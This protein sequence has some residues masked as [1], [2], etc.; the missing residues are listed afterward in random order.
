MDREEARKNCLAA[1]MRLF[2][3]ESPEDSAAILENAR[4]IWSTTVVSV[5]FGY[6]L[7]EYLIVHD[8]FY[9]FSFT[10]ER[11]VQFATT[12]TTFKEAS[13]LIVEAVRI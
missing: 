1:G 7:I 12:S 5:Y 2:I 9:G 6:V 11:T 8:M 4:K 13:K 10:E 3:V